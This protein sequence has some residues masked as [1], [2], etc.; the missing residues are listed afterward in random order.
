MSIAGKHV[1]MDLIESWPD[2]VLDILRTNQELIKQYLDEEKRVE[3][4]GREDIEIRYFPPLNPHKQQYLEVDQVINEILM[5]QSFV[6][7]HATRLTQ[8]EISNIIRDGLQPLTPELVKEKAGI[9]LR[10]NYISASEAELI[11][12]NNSSQEENREKMVWLFH[13]ISTLKDRGSLI[14]LFSYWGG[15]AIYRHFQGD[16]Y[17]S[18]DL[19]QIGQ[20]CI[21]V[22]SLP[23]AEMESIQTISDRMIRYW[24]SLQSLEPH[25]CEFDHF[26]KHTVEV[27]EIISIGDQMFEVLTCYSNW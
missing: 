9:L 18:P 2:S 3:L 19:K 7:F 1:I 24:S 20:P 22:C 12:Q 6:G 17:S 8:S 14:N 11:I 21:V 5:G 26:V 10:D 25:S 15:E 4:L 13:C 27:I 16:L 23:G